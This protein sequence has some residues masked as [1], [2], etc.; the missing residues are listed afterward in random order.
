MCWVTGSGFKM[1]LLTWPNGSNSQCKFLYWILPGGDYML[2]Y[3]IEYSLLG[4][5]VQMSCPP[6]ATNQLSWVSE[7]QL[8]L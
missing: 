5:P 3:S 8:R 2:P 7:P 4:L 6:L 1:A